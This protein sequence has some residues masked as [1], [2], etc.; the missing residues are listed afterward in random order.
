MVVQR[1][2]AHIEIILNDH[3][4]V[5]YADED[6]PYEHEWPELDDVMVGADGGTYGRARADFGCILIA[7]LSDISPTLQWFIQQREMHQQA[8]RN[9]NAAAIPIFNGSIN[10]LSMNVSGQYRRGRITGPA[11]GF[12]MAAGSTNEIRF[13][14]DLWTP[15]VGGG[16]FTAPQTD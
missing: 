11:L 14:F 8:V 3:E 13:K 10:D 1:S 5:G 16:N 12:P 9:G 15:N 7:R 2:H 6:Q 4:F